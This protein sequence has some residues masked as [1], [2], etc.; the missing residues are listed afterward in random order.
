H[1]VIQWRKSYAAGRLVDHS[2]DT[3][4]D[5]RIKD[6]ERMVGR[7]TMEN[8]LLKKAVQHTLQERSEDAL[9]ISGPGLSGG[10]AR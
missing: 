8:E 7:L 5:K 3:A 2:R 9:I 4:Q 10:D 6:L 1:L